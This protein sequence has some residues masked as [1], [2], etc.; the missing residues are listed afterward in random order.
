[1]AARRIRAADIAPAAGAAQAFGAVKFFQQLRWAA[2]IVQEGAHESQIPAPGVPA[3]PPNRLHALLPGLEVE[4]TVV[5]NFDLDP[6]PLRLGS[7]IGRP[8]QADE[9][10]ARHQGQHTKIP[11][12]VGVPEHVD[13]AFVSAWTTVDPDSESIC[14]C[15]KLAL[16]HRRPPL[17]PADQR[18]ITF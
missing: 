11:I 18:P 12:G 15:S 9:T 17:H 10:G 3:F 7:R 5:E 6:F 16:E 8:Q 2:G 1:M 13:V 4:V 14:A